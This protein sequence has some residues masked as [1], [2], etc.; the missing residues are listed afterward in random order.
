M[1]A[2]DGRSCS[3][4]SLAH[5]DSYNR[6]LGGP[7]GLAKAF[8]LLSPAT[9]PDSLFASR[10]SSVIRNASFNSCGS[11]VSIFLDCTL[12]EEELKIFLM[13]RKVIVEPQE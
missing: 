2:R 3:L 4:S 10:P 1:Y 13:A 8:F 5:L 12:T 7:F 6:R 11:D 9:M